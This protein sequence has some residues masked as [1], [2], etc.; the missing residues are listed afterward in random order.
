MSPDSPLSY[1]VP[2]AEAAFQDPK[3]PIT[4]PLGTI[5][6]SEEPRSWPDTPCDDDQQK[7]NDLRWVLEMAGF[8]GQEF[9]T[10]FAVAMAESGGRPDAYNGNTRSGDQSYGLFQINMKGRL[11]P[12]RRAHF[13]LASNDD[14]YDPVTNAKVAFEMSNGGTN[15]YPWGAFRNKSYRRYL[16]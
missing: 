6:Q 3:P 1:I 16:P 11:G 7:C 2:H 13:G 5:A 8:S 12:A 15:W 10:A 9:V 4:L 14:L